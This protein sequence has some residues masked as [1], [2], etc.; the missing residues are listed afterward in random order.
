M[1]LALDTN[2]YTD[3]AAGDLQAVR[4]IE[5]AAEVF[6]PFAVLA[7]LRAGFA[8][9]N[10]GAENALTLSAFLS[11]PLIQSLYPNDDTVTAYAA[12]YADLRRRGRIVPHNDLWI[13]ALCVQ[14]NLTLFTRDRH[15]DELPQIP[16][17]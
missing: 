16:R 15:F 4:I 5:S 11:K 1:R 9:G 8:A 2:R 17:C 13:A 6:V 10:R 7:E 14:H 12:L 3:A